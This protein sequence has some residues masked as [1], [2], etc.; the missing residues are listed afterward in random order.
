LLLGFQLLVRRQ[1]RRLVAEPHHGDSRPALLKS[2]HHSITRLPL[3]QTLSRWNQGSSAVAERV[4]AR[5]VSGGL[6]QGLL[7]PSPAQGHLCLDS[8][9]PRW[10]NH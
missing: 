6:F 2:P 1:S 10:Y 8:L 5:S 7:W 4:A 9:D 3:C